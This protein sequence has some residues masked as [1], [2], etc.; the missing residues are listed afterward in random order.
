M[1]SDLTVASRFSLTN[2]VNYNSFWICFTLWRQD[3]PWRGCCAWSL[4][5]S[6]DACGG[7]VRCWQRNVSIS[8]M[9]WLIKFNC[10]KSLK[11]IL[12]WKDFCK[13]VL[14]LWNMVSCIPLI[15]IN[16]H[17]QLWLHLR[18]KRSFSWLWIF[19]VTKLFLCSFLLVDVHFLC[20][21][22]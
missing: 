6:R 18:F 11:Q 8:D 13:N 16:K 1:T 7:R 10:V 19:T 4:Y 22:V 15:V 12:M 2:A 3:S 9:S 20:I 14:N 21:E 17:H 5:L